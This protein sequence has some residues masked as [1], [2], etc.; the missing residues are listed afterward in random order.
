MSLRVRRRLGWRIKQLRQQ[1]KL[2]QVEFAEQLGIS[3]SYLAD[4]ERGARNISID[5]LTM[6]AQGF[7]IP[8]SRLL[9][10]V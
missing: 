6:I 2:T 10:G 1:R 8:L 9:S 3:R 5:M 4:C 7:G